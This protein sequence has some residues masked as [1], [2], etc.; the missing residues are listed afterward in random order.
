MIV[1]L[2][3]CVVLQG[4]HASQ[5]P[6][7]SVNIR[8]SICNFYQSA[9]L[10]VHTEPN[11]FDKLGGSR[12]PKDPGEMKHLS[13]QIINELKLL[14][15]DNSLQE[16]IPQAERLLFK[17]EGTLRSYTDKDLKYLVGNIC[18]VRYYLFVFNSCK[19]K[20]R[21]VPVAQDLYTFADED[22]EPWRRIIAEEANV[23]QQLRNGTFKPVYSS[24]YQAQLQRSQKPV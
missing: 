15:P 11:R 16:S 7:Y 6:I 10:R 3:C 9:L 23:A 22:M 14:D 19:D 18:S 13:E 4:V 20:H 5:D 12:W 2:F 1:G 24:S 17:T 8:G 21:R